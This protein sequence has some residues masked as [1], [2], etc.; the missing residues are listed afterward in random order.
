MVTE[1]GAESRQSADERRPGGTIGELLDACPG[2]ME[3]LE[4]FGIRLDPWT[5]IALHATVE[6]LAEY[7]A[8]RDPG[9]L[10]AAIDRRLAAAGE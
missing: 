3:V 2:V 8:L 6:E 7:S 5:I 9:E 1:S 4:E 10:R